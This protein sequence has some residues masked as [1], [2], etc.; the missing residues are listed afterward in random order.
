MGLCQTQKNQ[1]QENGETREAV[2]WKVSNSP[3]LGGVESLEGTKSL[4]HFGRKTYS[5]VGKSQRCHG[6]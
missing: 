1:H 2:L 6:H 5:S 4:T 3:M